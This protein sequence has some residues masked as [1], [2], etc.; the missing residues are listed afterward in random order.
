MGDSKDGHAYLYASNNEY[1]MGMYA[2]DDTLMRTWQIHSA[3]WLS[4]GGET[5]G[6]S[7]VGGGRASV[8]IFVLL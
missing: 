4:G 3:P 7:Q 8:G 2:R 5:K 6:Q 1:H